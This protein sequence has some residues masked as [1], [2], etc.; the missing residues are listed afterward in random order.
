MKHLKYKILILA[1]AAFLPAAVFAS[2][3]NGTIDSDYKY[4]W[5]EN[6][7]WINFNASNGNVS[8]TDSAITGYAWSDNY[9]WINLSPASSGVANDGYGDLSGYAWGENLGWINFSAVSIDSSGYF[10]GYAVISQDSSQI[11]F[12]CSNIDSCAESDFKIRTDWRPRSVRPACNNALDDDGDGKIDYPSDPGCSSLTDDDEI[13]PNSVN[14]EMFNPP[15]APFK[16]LINNGENTTS[17]FLVE[18][19]LFAGSDT[20][21]MAISNFFDF[22]NASQIPFQEEIGWNLCEG[23]ADVCEEIATAG[24]SHEF[25][26]YVKFYT[27]YGLASETVSDGI[28]YKIEIDLEEEPEEETFFEPEKKE[29]GIAEEKAK[30]KKQSLPEPESEEESRIGQIINKLKEILESTRDKIITPPK[31]LISRLLPIADEFFNPNYFKIDLKKIPLAKIAFEKLSAIIPKFL[32]P[33]SLKVAPPRLA[34]EKIVPQ[35]ASFAFRGKWRLIPE[36][37]IKIFVFAPL[38][39][40]LSNLAKKFPALDKT[41]QEVGITRMADVS[42]LQ[43]AKFTLR[44]LASD[45]GLR[46]VKIGSQDFYLPA[47]IP[48]AQLSAEVKQ[49]IPAEIIFAKAGA[50]L[51]DF[52]IDL[53]LDNQGKTRQKI[54]AVSGKPIK[55]VVKPDGPAD[56]VKGYLMFTGKYNQSLSLRGVNE[57]KRNERRSNPAD[58]P[59]N[60]DNNLATIKKTRDYFSRFAMFVTT[61]GLFS[62]PALAKEETD[63]A[64]YKLQDFFSSMFFAKPSFAYQ[65]EE[66][67]EAE[68]KLVL[69]EFDYND[70]DNDGIW[71]AEIQAPAVEGEYEVVTVI[72]YTDPE[73]GA[74]A[75]RLT[76]VVDPEGYVYETYKDKEIRI[77]G[78]IASLYWLNP[79][80]KKYQLWPAAEYIQENPQIT[81]ISGKYSFL[82]PAGTYYLTIEAPGYLNYEGKPFQVREGSGVH[83]NIELKTKYWWLKIINWQ[84][85]ILIFVVLLLFYN[86][87]RDKIRN[88]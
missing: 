58:S 69:M 39:D 60:P 25:R 31:I 20:K 43:G 9:G 67:V 41:F 52:E 23:Q 63:N 80:T 64:S 71:T 28:I 26:V 30:K 8:V 5:S 29:E 24:Q 82:V 84:T 51:I 50:E 49:K 57:A 87:Y 13:D 79:G 83:E 59:A 17:D 72:Y 86:F 56:A 18:L 70:S 14:P 21:K 62:K 3:T 32:R 68:E 7:G 77:P 33:K 10:G 76:T 27:K 73:L 66:P 16:V 88:R 2:N 75:I 37:P 46:K 65:Y 74:R 55:L 35:E 11:S 15:I 12:N 53:T 81:A 34:L 47:G 40:Y 48:L 45:S 1:I 78:A 36:K 54:T 6:F 61:R 38:P 19:K 22:R 85:I 4:A 44:G 42:K